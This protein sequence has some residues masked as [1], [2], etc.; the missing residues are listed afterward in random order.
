MARRNHKHY[1]SVFTTWN[2]RSLLEFI[3]S[4]DCD[5]EDQSDGRYKLPIAF[6]IRNFLPPANKVFEGYVF[7]GVCLSKGHGACMA[8]GG[9]HGRGYAW[10]GGMHGGH[11]WQERHCM[12]GGMHGRGVCMAEWCAWQGGMC[13]RGCLA[14]EHAWWGHVWQG[15]CV[16]GG[17]VWQGGH[18]WQEGGMHGRGVHGRGHAWQGGM[19]GRGCVAGEMVTAAHGTHPTGMQSCYPSLKMMKNYA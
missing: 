15:V 18:A 11:V 4:G 10:W 12:A 19:C 1:I 14:G 6:W 3:H 9:M 2:T 7:T 13:G 5:G 8:W 17:H 16:A